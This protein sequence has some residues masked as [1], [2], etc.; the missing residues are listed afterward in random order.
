VE[1][2]RTQPVDAGNFYK[3]AYTEDVV[4]DMTDRGFSENLSNAFAWQYSPLVRS[5]QEFAYFGDDRPDPNY[6]V[7]DD[8]E[9]F[10]TYKSSFVNAKSKE[11]TQFIKD[12]IRKS[13]KVRADLANTS[14]LSISVGCW[15]P[16]SFE[17]C[18]CLTC[19]WSAGSFSKGRNDCKAGFCCWC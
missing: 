15:H 13:E 2:K 1:Y 3:K 18:L 7:W 14:V 10:E 12:S 6:N 4:G 19:R 16:R 9:G 17:Y 5:I 8:I 11:H